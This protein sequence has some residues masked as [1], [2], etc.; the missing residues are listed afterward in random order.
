MPHR[1]TLHIL[2]NFSRREIYNLYKEYVGGAQEMVFSLHIHILQEHGKS[3]STI[4]V[5]LRS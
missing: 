5:F 2:D 4:F 3:N 1:D